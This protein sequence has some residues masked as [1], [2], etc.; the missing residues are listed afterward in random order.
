MTLEQILEH[1][2]ETIKKSPTFT[3]KKKSQKKILFEAD[4]PEEITRFMELNW[5]ESGRTSKNWK[6][7]HHKF[8]LHFKHRKFGE[9]P[10]HQL[11]PE[12]FS[13]LRRCKCEM[14]SI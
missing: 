2:M 14:A 8:T 5:T 13:S 6:K 3:G 10:H 1:I 11:Q 12:L 4:F 7:S 9:C